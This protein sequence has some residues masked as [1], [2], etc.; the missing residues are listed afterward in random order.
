MFILQEKIVFIPCDVTWIEFK[1]VLGGQKHFISTCDDMNNAI[2]M[3]FSME[4]S[5]VIII[6]GI[7]IQ[8]ICCEI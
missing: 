1:Y 3:G 5:L 6:H 7:V 4:L 8:K 2:W